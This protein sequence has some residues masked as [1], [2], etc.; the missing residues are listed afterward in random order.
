MQWR[1]QEYAWPDIDDCALRIVE[2]F[3]MRC[4]ERCAECPS[5]DT[6]LNQ[7]E[8]I[9]GDYNPQSEMLFVGE[10]PG[11]EEKARHRIFVG[12]TGQEFN[13]TYLPLAGTSRQEVSVTNCLKCWW[14]D[15]S[16]PPP[17]YLVKSC[18]EF[19][20]RRELAYHKPRVVIL[21]GGVANSLMKYD[22]EL[23][24]GIMHKGTLL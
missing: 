14:S 19:H 15:S 17:V 8:V 2:W 22:I 23:E 20:L 4:T 7:Q 10:G 6:I 11:R 3:I 18:T 16:D 13:D 9:S 12:Q 1:R 24:H 21:M 5:R